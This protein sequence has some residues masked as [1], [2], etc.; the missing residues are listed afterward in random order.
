MDIVINYANGVSPQWQT[1]LL[2]DKD[3]S[4][5]YLLRGIEECMAFADKVFLVVAAYSQ[6][7]EWVDRST[8]QIILHKEIIPAYA[9]L[10]AINIAATELFHFKIP[11]IGEKFIQMRDDTFPVAKC[12]PEDFFRA[13]KTVGNIPSKKFFASNLFKRQLRSISAFARHTASLPPSICYLHPKKGPAPML[14]DICEEVFILSSE[15]IEESLFKFGE[16]ASLDRNLF[17]DYTYLTGRMIPMT[18]P[19]R[20]IDCSSASMR[21]IT[22]PTGKFVYI[23][24]SSASKEN[25]EQYS[26]GILEAFKIRFPNKSKFEKI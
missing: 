3:D 8:L 23:D 7:P 20:S 18:V 5:R 25:H 17:T 15:Q 1:Q 26:N 9:Y 14:T 12:S 21:G 16:T 6:I 2:H 22:H 24:N 11:G 10:P 13:G 19:C 4:L